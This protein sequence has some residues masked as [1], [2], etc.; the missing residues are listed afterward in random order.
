MNDENRGPTRAGARARARLRPFRALDGE[1]VTIGGEHRY[2]LFGTDDDAIVD[3]A[4]IATVDAL[5]FILR[6]STRRHLLV[7]FAFNYDVN[8]ILRDVDPE[9]LQTL[10][11]DGEVWIELAGQRYYVEWIPGK[12]FG[13]STTDPVSGRK[14]RAKVWDCWGFFQASFVRALETWS[15]DDDSGTIAQMKKQR[16]KFTLAQMEE[17]RAYNARECVLL[18]ELMN[19][20]R[21]ALYDVDLKPRSWLGAGS[22]A[23]ALLLKHDIDKHVS[24]VGERTPTLDEDVLLRA[25]F[26][27]RTEVFRQGCFDV[28]VALDINSAYPTAA[29]MLPTAHGKWK[30]RREYDPSAPWA[31]WRVSWDV[32]DDAIVAPFPYRQKRAIY[33]P[34]RGVGIYHAVELQAAIAAYGEDCFDVSSGYVFEPSDD[35]RPFAFIEDVFA[36]R[37]ELKAAGHPSEKVLKLGINSVYGKLAQGAS[38]N[39]LRPRFQEYFWSGWITAWTRAQVFAAMMQRPADVAAVATD[40]IIFSGDEPDVEIGPGLGQWERTIYRHLFIAQPGMYSAIA[41]RKTIKRSRGFFT[42]EI[43]YPA[44]QRTWLAD[45]P[46]GMQRCRTHRFVGLG[47]ALLRRNFDVWRSWEDGV[48]TLSLYSSRKFYDERDAGERWRRV[49]PPGE[50][51]KSSELSERYVPKR[52]AVELDPDDEEWIQGT[53]QPSVALDGD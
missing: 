40:G 41:G 2:V 7:A 47:T 51:S 45:G 46:D 42:R 32:G 8:M 26:G 31:L 24:R 38:R 19:R 23:S 11:Q 21:D 49:H 50:V 43:N 37:R 29:T 27:G 36:Q 39:G 33:Y 4:G 35:A 17:I 14:L 9:A 44:L 6:Q 10:W 15:V 18:V 34:T 25:Y 3:D 20:V 16:A 13:V 28:G 5:D 1:G 12:L 30:R 52:A 53:E 48:R 22:I